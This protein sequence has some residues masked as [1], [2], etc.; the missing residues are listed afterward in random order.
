MI[1]KNF[2]AIIIY[3]I[4][5]FFY[6]IF[7]GLSVIKRYICIMKRFICLAV[8]VI[9]IFSY[10]FALPSSANYNS[11][12]KTEADIV[13]L[14][15]LDDGTVIFDKNSEK[16]NAMASLAKI[17]TAS[18]VIENCEDLDKKILVPEYCVSLL[19]G[20]KS[21]PA[22]LKAG[23]EL[24]IRQLL[25]CLMVKSANESAYVLAD[26]IGNGSID[27]FVDKMNELVAS[28]G[29]KNTHFENP[30]G[31]D[32]EN[33]YTTARDMAL[34]VKHALGLPSFME[35]CNTNKYTLEKTNK[36]GER[37]FYN[38]N[39]LINSN[40]RTYY[41][42]YVQGIKAGTTEQAGCCVVS[43][44]SKDGYNYC[45]IIM[46]AP[47]KDTNGDGTK[48]NMAF[49]ESKRLY[50]WAF[51]NLRLE[52]IADTS[53]IVTVVDVKLSFDADHV[54]L[55]PANDVTAIVPV[56]NGED[57]VLIEPIEEETPKSINAPVKKG[58]KVGTA[59]ILYAGTIIA[60]VD[61][62]AADDVK[63]NIFLWLVNA[64]KVV[65]T[66]P[67]FLILLAIA[68]IAFIS[69][70]Y[71]MRKQTDKKMKR[72][73]GR[74]RPVMYSGAK[75]LKNTKGKGRADGKPSDRTKK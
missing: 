66:S 1:F 24:S 53:K 65:V 41:Y 2:F 45:C 38:S 25:Y 21:A 68:V 62:V 63:V 43:K 29:C 42:K 58:E 10:A 56:G 6:N 52:K 17:I 16:R 48:D 8:T 60:T 70:V 39:W 30:H 14:F 5:L 73:L 72:S 50:K 35:I 51:D 47:S 46:N 49:T 34:I 37:N 67:I 9:L 19:R 64:V 12:L 23:E 69:Y 22:V 31:L 36:S 71:L 3:N 61:L 32:A 27:N 54:R 11:E 13:L 18:V 44:A 28:L 59:N 33:Q 57:S 20:T 40:Y 75:N 26:Y 55:V 7:K 15:S 4:I 74:T